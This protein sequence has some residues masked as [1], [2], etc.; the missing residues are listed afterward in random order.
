MA[1]LTREFPPEVYGGA[2]VYAE[3]LAAELDRMDGLDLTVHCFGPARAGQA[4]I[5]AYRPWERL[6][7]PAPHAAALGTMSVDLEMAAGMHV[8]DIVHSNTWYTNLA[9]HLGKLLYRIPHV[10]TSHSLEPL[11]RWKADQLGAGYALSSYCEQAGLEGADAIIAVS[12]QMRADILSCYPAVDPARIHII[13]N[14]VDPAV[15]R[16]VPG[17]GVL[18]ELQISTARPIVLFAGRITEQKGIMHLLRAAPRLDPSA[19]LVLCAAAP[20][21]ARIEQQFRSSVAE[22]MRTRD[23]VF[24]IDEMLPRTKMIE[25]LTHARV[26][27]CPSVYEP[28]GLVNLEAMACETPVVATR[29]GGIPEIVVEG[30]T[31]LL[32]DLE[33]DAGWEPGRPDQFSSALAEAIN[34][35][36]RDQDLAERMG[37][38]GRQRVLEQFTW[39]VTAQKTAAL[40][41]R[42]RDS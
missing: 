29:T 38:A 17:T 23:A 9:G 22:L 3:H 42:E 16:P 6:A 15:Y 37:R 41:A 19:Q 7:G 31:G 2:G 20:D 30:E 25:L 27:V 8:A 34:R 18:N 35:L 5:R 33:V 39:K 14:G 36:L 10:V 40:Y 11:R 4:A 21:N 28:F 12:G 32:V 24:W 26:F 1:F 13:H